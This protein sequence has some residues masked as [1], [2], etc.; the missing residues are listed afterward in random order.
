MC[1]QHGVLRAQLQRRKIGRKF[2]LELC[3]IRI[4]GNSR[5]S[6]CHNSGREVRVSVRAWEKKRKK[7]EL[8]F[9]LLESEKKDE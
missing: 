8:K 4:G 7:E 3:C 2:L 6:S 5:V 9:N 1:D